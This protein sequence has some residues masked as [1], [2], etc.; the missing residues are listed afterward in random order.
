MIE[1]TRLLRPPWQYIADTDVYIR[2]RRLAVV[3]ESPLICRRLQ[4]LSAIATA[5]RILFFA[6]I[7]TYRW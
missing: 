1:V 2:A 3:S 6:P 5:E 4:N 7:G